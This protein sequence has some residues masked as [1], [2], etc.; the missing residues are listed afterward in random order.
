MG[1]A[2]IV[3][4]EHAGYQ[5]D[6]NLDGVVDAFDSALYLNA[7]QT[8]IWTTAIKGQHFRYL[9]LNHDG[10]RNE[11]DAQVIADWVAPAP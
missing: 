5:M 2:F 8:G 11:D 9:D 3:Y 4:G 6:V 10:V 7:A 1:A